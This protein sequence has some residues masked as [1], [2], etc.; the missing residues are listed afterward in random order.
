MITSIEPASVGPGGFIDPLFL[1]WMGGERPYRVAARY[2]YHS[3]LLGRI[4][5]IPENADYRTD[6]ASVPRVFWRIVPPH[7]KYAPAAVIHDWLCDQ[8][9][10]GGIDSETTHRI[11]LEAM[12]LLE[13]PWWKRKVMYRAVRWFGPRFDAQEHPSHLS[14]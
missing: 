3:K 7:G 5:E 8:A 10:K 2:R 13:V 1:E 9:G 12:E 11:F 4:I 6:F 14:D